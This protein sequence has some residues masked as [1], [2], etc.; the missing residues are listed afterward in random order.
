[1]PGFTIV[2]VDPGVFSSLAI[3][4]NVDPFASEKYF[5]REYIPGVKRGHIDDYE[6]YVADVVGH[7]TIAVSL[8]DAH[9]KAVVISGATYKNGLDLNSQHTAAAVEQEVVGES[10]SIGTRRV[11]PQ[12]CGFEHEGQF[13]D[14][15]VTASIEFWLADGV[16]A[17]LG[18][19]V[20]KPR[21]V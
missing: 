3:G 19:L 9:V 14:F 1:M 17:T 18:W 2:F 4:V 21:V 7:R 5:H 8:A 11:E 10:G 13:S 6:I 16:I 12:R 15:A 20:E